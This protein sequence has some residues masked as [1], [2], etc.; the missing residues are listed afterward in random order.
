M[1]FRM[2][3]NPFTK[4]SDVPPAF[5]AQRFLASFINT[6]SSPP[7]STLAFLPGDKVTKYNYAV[8]RSKILQH[9]VSSNNYDFSNEFRSFTLGNPFICQHSH[10]SFL[11]FNSR[12]IH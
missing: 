12:I 2:N 7:F 3:S 5:I 11:T 1:F 4:E 6:C 8:T 9:T 10:L